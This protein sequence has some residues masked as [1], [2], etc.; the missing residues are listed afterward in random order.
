[1][2]S[3][4]V[5]LLA[6]M[7]FWIQPAQAQ[8]SAESALR[9]VTRIY[10]SPGYIGLPAGDC[11]QFRVLGVNAN[12][13]EVPVPGRVSWE[14]SS[15]SGKIAPDGTYTASKIVGIHDMAITASVPGGMTAS[16][17][18][19]IFNPVP[20][21]G[22]R[23][24]RIWGNKAPSQ[25]NH[26]HGLIVDS[27][28][29]V[30]VADTNNHRIQKFDSS[31]KYVASWG[32]YGDKPGQLI[33]PE[34]LAVDKQ[35]NVYVV[36]NINN[37]LQQFDSTGVFL[38]QIKANES[39]TAFMGKPVCVAVDESDNLYIGEEKTK[40]RPSGIAR[41]DLTGKVI[42]RFSIDQ[43]TV[44][45]E[46]DPISL[47]IHNGRIYIADRGQNRVVV[48]ETS[49]K[50]LRVM[51]EEQPINA[52]VAGDG[53]IYIVSASHF[54]DKYNSEG[55]ASGSISCSHR[56]ATGLFGPCG[57]AVSPQGD[58][59]VTDVVFNMVH[60][61]SPSG[62]CVSRWGTCDKGQFL[63][64]Y[65]IA[66][67]PWGDVYVTDAVRGRVSKFDSTGNCIT[68]LGA[69]SY[70]SAPL[71]GVHGI[72]VDNR[73][74]VYMTNP[75]KK[76]FVYDSGGKST[77]D[78]SVNGPDG[79]VSIAVDSAYDVY[80]TGA[81][82]SG[83]YKL[84]AADN[85]TSPYSFHRI[86]EAYKYPGE[87]A[88]DSKGN[89]YLADRGKVCRFTSSGQELPDVPGLE[90]KDG[91]LA[92]IANSIAIDKQ[93]NL[94]STER[95]VNK[96]RKFDPTMKAVAEWGSAGGG[97]G[98]FS[99]PIGLAVSPDGS[100]YISDYNNTRIQKFVPV[101]GKYAFG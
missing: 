101:A 68:F 8:T 60:K 55:Q 25:F 40:D 36:D 59:Y 85:Q 38:K 83:V 73:G 28:G 70:A 49:G 84:G 90:S 6:L 50:F 33:S 64:V 47:T 79:T 63:Y 13:D 44:P 65:G 12:G 93:D 97:P 39:D 20:E 99:D 10:I 76:I 18:V 86:N 16:A 67:D 1:M 98:Q 31:G 94:Y 54:I 69:N 21:N 91:N 61:F 92:L 57:V 27:D 14:A 35:H 7:I 62:E 82:P 29:F 23:L 71:H 88:L 78:W 9:T 17:I 77:A 53:T 15:K 51:R 5:V 56:D 34:S 37:R 42:K 3:L 2:K 52:A 19:E 74:Y 4:V 48:L 95:A 32:S 41:I 96:I 30:Y 80:I 45:G 22:Y 26:P 75:N 58:V 24:D 100:V 11:Q 46:T 43:D 87:V 81:E 72:T 89:I 66:A